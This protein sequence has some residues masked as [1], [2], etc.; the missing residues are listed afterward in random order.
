MRLLGV[1]AVGFLTLTTACGGGGGDGDG[2]PGPNPQQT[3]NEIVPSVTTLNLSA[4]GGATIQMT[5][6][7]TEGG[8]IS[9]P[10]TYSYTSRSTTI[11][12][13]NQQG[14]VVG[15][16]AGTTTIDI[17]LSRSGVTKQATV[18]VIVS[19]TLG[20]TASVAA[21]TTSNT[22]QPQVV[23]IAR[24]GTV[25]W[26]FGSVEHNVFFSG[27]SGAPSNIPTTS[28]ASISRTFNTAGNFTY[29]CNL[30][31]GMTGTVIVR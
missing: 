1:L 26:S 18:N 22:F 21:G 23:A 10:G 24:T 8:T 3:L 29:D 20:L 7:D 30:H 2:G 5:A 19:G 14:A 27:A 6:R 15:I 12:E 28:G 11:A 16:S 17:S 25:T 4:G 31:A 13:V 9:N